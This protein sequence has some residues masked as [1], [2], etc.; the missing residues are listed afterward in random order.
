M[1]SNSAATVEPIETIRKFAIAVT[2]PI[3][4]SIRLQLI[5]QVLQTLK[6]HIDRVS[7][8]DQFRL[9]K[10]L[11][12]AI[13]YTEMDK[14]GRELMG[15]IADQCSLITL[16]AGFQLVDQ[17][18]FTIDHIRIDKYMSL[19]RLMLARLLRTQFKAIVLLESGKRQIITILFI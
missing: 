11:F 7:Q 16:M 3:D 9:W 6:P 12:Y 2:Q 14:G 8:D 1:S 15:V 10:G 19:V 17:D 13:W 18:W 5:E 4:G